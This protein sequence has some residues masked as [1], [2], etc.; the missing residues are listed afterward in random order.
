MD[1]I[2]TF[3][4][5]LLDVAH[6]HELVEVLKEV[7]CTLHRMQMRI[8]VQNISVHQLVEIIEDIKRQYADDLSVIG[9]NPEAVKH[10]AVH[11]RHTGKH[12]FDLG[13]HLNKVVGN[14]FLV[15]G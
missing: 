7:L 10:I 9:N 2:C 6:K 15:F 8:R 12:A 11:L 1:Y 13:Y 14:I 3:D 4:K 5:F